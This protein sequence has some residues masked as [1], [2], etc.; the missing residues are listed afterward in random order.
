MKKLNNLQLIR[1]IAAVYVLLFH[2]SG[3]LQSYLNYDYAYGIFKFGDAGVDMFFVLSGFVIYYVHNKDIG[4]PEKVKSFFKKRIIRVY[5]IYWV[6][7]I[8]LV[9]V[10]FIIPTF[11]SDSVLN[12]LN[13]VKSFVLIPQPEENLPLNVAW[14]LSYE[15][16][17]YCMFGLLIALKRKLVLPIVLLWM[18][19]TFVHFII[20]SIIGYVDSSWINFVFNPFNLEFLSGVLIAH[21]VLK[22]YTKNGLVFIVLGLCGAVVA[23]INKS[24]SFVELH[25]VIEY[26]LPFAFIIYGAVSYEIERQTNPS[27][28][29]VY[30]GDASYSIYLIHYPM[31]SVV[32]KLFLAVNVYSIIGPFLAATIM[33]ISTIIAGCTFHSLIEKPL[34]KF[35]NKALYSKNQTSTRNVKSA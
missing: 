35:L 2:T 27:K 29:F 9:P 12:P 31:L 26:G 7:L 22:N 8:C 34:L 18:G 21:L 5:P 10:Y 3:L 19:G 14:S 20:Q 16:L 1:G 17:F 32:N 25:R 13:L 23:W 28:L 4:A 30:L 11:G 15:I 33:I 6:V 24:Y